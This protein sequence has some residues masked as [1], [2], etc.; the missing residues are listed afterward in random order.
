MADGFVAQRLRRVQGCVSTFAGDGSE[1]ENSGS[2]QE[3]LRA[4]PM[5]RN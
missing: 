2:L 1:V 3:G 5:G 4:D